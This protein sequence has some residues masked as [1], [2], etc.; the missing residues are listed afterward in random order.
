MAQDNSSGKLHSRSCAV[1]EYFRKGTESQAFCSIHSGTTSDGSTTIASISA[2]DVVPILPK[3]PFIIGDDP[4]HTEVPSSAAVSRE[5][6]L[7]RRRTNVL[8]S[9]DVGDGDEKIRL[10]QPARLVIEED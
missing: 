4:Y 1:S 7:I 9:L 5:T 3:E 2:L 6:G 8:D 10:A